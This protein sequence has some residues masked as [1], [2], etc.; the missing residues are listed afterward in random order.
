MSEVLKAVSHVMRTLLRK[1]ASEALLLD[2]Y[3]TTCLA[4]DEM[5]FEVRRVIRAPARLL[6]LLK[7]DV[8]QTSV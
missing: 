5:I 7:A 1:P 8:L 3:A 4:L 2:N 6:V